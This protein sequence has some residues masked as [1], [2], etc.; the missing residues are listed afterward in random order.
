LTAINPWAR[1]LT[2]SFGEVDA[3]QLFDMGL[4]A[5]WISRSATAWLGLDEHSGEWRGAEHHRHNS[6]VSTFAIVAQ[7][8][9]HA[10]TLALLLSGHCAG[11]IL[12]LKGIVNVAECPDRPAVIHGVQ[13]LFR[14]PGWLPAWP[15]ADRR[16]RLVF[17]VRGIPQAWI[18]TLLE[19]LE[20]EVGEA[21]ALT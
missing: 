12:R 8:P 14:P 2:A 6:E 16:S 5:S 11:D 20:I 17:I 9:I 19:A 3:D 15:S 18:E 7:E 13:H 1:L 21:T 4:D 10:V